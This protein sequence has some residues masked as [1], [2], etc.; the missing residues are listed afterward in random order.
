[1][2]TTNTALYREFRKLSQF[3]F[4]PDQFEKYIREN[5]SVVQ[6]RLAKDGRIF[7]SPDDM[8]RWVNER[9]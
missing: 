2:K 8:F 3:E 1:M 6:K 9:T 5:W 7:S 4:T